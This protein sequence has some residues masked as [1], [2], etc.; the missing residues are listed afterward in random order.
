[1]SRHAEDGGRPRRGL[2][3]RLGRAALAPL[4]A[5]RAGESLAAIRDDLARLRDAGRTREIRFEDYGG[6]DLKATAFISGMRVEAFERRLAVRRRATARNAYV[7]WGLGALFLAAGL[8]RFATAAWGV[9]A[10][11][12]ALQF[13]PAC[14]V[15]FLLAF[16]FGLENAQ[17]RH[18]RRVT[19]T[20][21]LADPRDI[22]PR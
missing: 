5:L 17:I 15:L 22:W 20:D 8:S 4:R 12:A 7:F 14:A 2:F 21:Y 10:V 11:V 18:R 6:Y 9:S 19:A 3:R 16:R 1:M 13:A